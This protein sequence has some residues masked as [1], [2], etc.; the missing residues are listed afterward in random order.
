MAVKRG[1]AI[2]GVDPAR[3]ARAAAGWEP[4]TVG[5]FGSFPENLR[6]V[7]DVVTKASDSLAPHYTPSR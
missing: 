4:N 6:K 3:H 5:C 2:S 7:V 1:F